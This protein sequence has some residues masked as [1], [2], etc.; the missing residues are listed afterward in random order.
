MRR[1][2]PVPTG[3]PGAA[4]RPAC[5]GHRPATSAWGRPRTAAA[6][7]AHACGRTGTRRATAP[8]AGAEVPGP[9]P[10]KQA[11]QPTRGRSAAAGQRRRRDRGARPGPEGGA[12]LLPATGCRRTTAPGAGSHR[13]PSR[14]WRGEE[15]GT[16]RNPMLARKA[17]SAAPTGCPAP[18]ARQPCAR[19]ARSPTGGAMAGPASV[20]LRSQGLLG[21]AGD[22][23]RNIQMDPHAELAQD[24]HDPADAHARLAALDVHEGDVAGADHRGQV[25]LADLLCATDGPDHATDLFGVFDREMH[26]RS[27]SK[28]SFRL[29]WKLG[30]RNTVLSFCL[31]LHGMP[32][33][34]LDISLIV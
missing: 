32:S 5:A 22:F 12:T 7:V 20:G 14:R 4:P 25:V 28:F 11:R 8:G 18:A 23:R 6:G 19:P 31:Y 10:A 1:C 26:R 9:A 29:N 3:D 13:R 15:P 21:L 16:G 30:R 2:Q 17:H 24:I 33:W 27:T 34:T